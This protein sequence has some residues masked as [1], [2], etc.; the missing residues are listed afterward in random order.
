MLGFAALIV[1][2]TSMPLHAALD[3]EARD[4]SPV[5][6][7]VYSPECGACRQFD[8]EVGVKLTAGPTLWAV[9]VDQHKRAI[10]GFRIKRGVQR[11]RGRADNQRDKTEHE[12]CDSHQSLT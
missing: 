6:I 8:G 12:Q 5:L 3:P 10:A 4:S 7:Y 11:H 9:N 2:A 1:G